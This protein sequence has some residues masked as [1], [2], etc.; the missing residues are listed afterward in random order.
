MERRP[1][2]SLCFA[3]E[4]LLSWVVDRSQSGQ[5]DLLTKFT[6]MIS[7][8]RHQYAGVHLLYLIPRAI[9]MS[10]AIALRPPASCSSKRLCLISILIRPSKPYWVSNFIMQ[11][12]TSHSFLGDRDYTGCRESCCCYLT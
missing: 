1:V 7:N 9:A 5:V 12:A 4:S 11:G 6:I 10:S 8:R 3:C 2:A